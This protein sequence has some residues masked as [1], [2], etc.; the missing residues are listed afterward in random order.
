MRH[1]KHTQF[2]SKPVNMY[3]DR[4]HRIGGVCNFLFA[5]DSLRAAYWIQE[6]QMLVSMS[7]G[8]TAHGP[9][10][11]SL[12]IFCMMWYRRLLQIGSYGP[13][14]KLETVYDKFPE[15]FRSLIIW[16]DIQTIQWNRVSR[17]LDARH[18]LR[19]KVG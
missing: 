17:L 1:S 19:R 5:E 10:V 7:F 18:P 3:L 14:N 11:C 13:I 4:M 9:K 15:L 16:T 8:S 6:Y 12:S 2:M